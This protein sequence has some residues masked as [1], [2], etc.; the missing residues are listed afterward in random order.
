MKVVFRVAQF[1]AEGKLTLLPTEFQTYPEAEKSIDDL[2]SGTYQ[3]QKV[4]VKS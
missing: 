2:P 4:F 1:D 3:V